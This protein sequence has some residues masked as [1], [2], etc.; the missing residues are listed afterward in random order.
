MENFNDNELFKIHEFEFLI[1]SYKIYLN[2]VEKIKNNNGYITQDDF[3]KICYILEK[4]PTI[5]TELNFRYKHGFLLSTNTR[6]I[7]NKKTKIYYIDI[8]RLKKSF[9]RHILR[10]FKKLY[11]EEFL[12]K[13]K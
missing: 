12:I 2:I 4:M 11:K 6:K 9:K 13:Q 5:N 7:N 3:L 10:I 8:L 1:K